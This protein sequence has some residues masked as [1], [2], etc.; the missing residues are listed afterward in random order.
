MKKYR[1]AY[2]MAYQFKSNSNSHG[3]GTCCHTRADALNTED[4]ITKWC[5]DMATLNGFESVAL[6][7]FIRIKS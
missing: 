3:F 4:K 5:Q 7:N 6:M 1:Y 2:H